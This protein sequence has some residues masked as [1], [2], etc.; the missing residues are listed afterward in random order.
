MI[1]KV[2]DY[3]TGIDCCLQVP[4]IN[5]TLSVNFD[6]DACNYNLHLAIGN[7]KLDKNLLNYTFGQWDEVSLNGV[8]NL[9]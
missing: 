7:F 1:C 5:K 9:K 6:L 2:P 8:F 3:C 4:F